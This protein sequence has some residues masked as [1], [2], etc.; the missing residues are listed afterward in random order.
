MNNDMNNMN[1][2][3]NNQVPNN[4]NNVNMGQ[5]TNVAPVDNNVP[6]TNFNPTPQVASTNNKGGNNKIVIII[7]AIV[8]L[9]AIA[10]GVYF[11]TSGSSDKEK[12][13]NQT[14]EKEDKNDKEDKDD[15]E[16][17]NVK[18][19][20]FSTY[21]N[22]TFTMDMVME[23]DVDG[24]VL[25]VSSYAEGKADVKNRTDYMVT[26]VTTL[27]ETG[28][29]YSY[30]DLAAGYTYLSEDQVNWTSE[31]ITEGADETIELEAIINKI[32][33]NDP[34]VT[35]EADGHYR[36]KADFEEY[37]DVFAE[38]YVSDGYVTRLYYDLTSIGASEG[39]S[40]FTVDMKLSKFN[41][42]GDVVI[43]QTVVGSTSA[44]A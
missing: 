3:M 22:Y 33:N 35:K 7:V 15:K 18:L 27:G 6:N 23:M 39:F 9:V 37:Q 16:E 26:K 34:D 30:N 25:K 41:E 36:V 10:L 12:D 43:P 44:S 40:K 42:T 5:P 14:E 20:A 1:N 24:S 2:Q 38:V 19:H 31:K 13:N 8:A 11:L 32:N 21:E 28:T 29:Q 4:M 17:D